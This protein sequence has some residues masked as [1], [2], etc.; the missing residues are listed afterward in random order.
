MVA[1]GMVTAAEMLVCKLG[2]ACP[3]TRADLTCGS[4]VTEEME[5]VDARAPNSADARALLK[6]KALLAGR[7]CFQR[8]GSARQAA[9]QRKALSLCWLL[10][11]GPQA[12]QRGHLQLAKGR[13]SRRQTQEKGH[14]GRCRLLALGS[15]DQ[16]HELQRLRRA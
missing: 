4:H 7:R 10:T 11:A 15:S 5:A 2:T 16:R 8:G 9:A 3:T 6:L 13:P 1:L 14:R 12:A